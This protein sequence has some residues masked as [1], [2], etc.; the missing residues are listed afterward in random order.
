MGWMTFPFEADCSYSS[1][2]AEEI[3]DHSHKFEETLSSFR[4]VCDFIYAYSQRYK[5]L[6]QIFTSDI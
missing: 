2:L 3:P 4:V 5:Y 1:A 6:A